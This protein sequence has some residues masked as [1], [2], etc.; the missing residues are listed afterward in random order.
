MGSLDKFLAQEQQSDLESLRDRITE[1]T[2]D[3][4]DDVNPCADTVRSTEQEKTNKVATHGLELRTLG[5]EILESRRT[6]NIVFW[7][8]FQS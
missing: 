5:E 1:L 7:E 8:E 2:D 6:W 3:Y 4:D